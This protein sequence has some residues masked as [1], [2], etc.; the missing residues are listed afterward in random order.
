M[1]TCVPPPPRGVDPELDRVSDWFE[2][3]DDLEEAFGM[4]VRTAIDE[5]IDTP[6]TGRWNFNDCGKQELAYA[7]VK[8]E[9]VI[10]ARFDLASGL[11]R[12]DYCVDGVDVDCKWSKKWGGW[13]IPREAVGHVCLLVWGCDDDCEFAVGV[14]RIRGAIL[15]GGNQ[16]KKRKIQSP[17]G[18]GEIRWLVPC[19]NSLPPNFLLQLPDEDRKA[20]LGH[21]GGDARARELFLRCEGVIIRRHTIES[22]GQQI[23]E[24]RRF[25]GETRQEMRD[26]GF[27][28]LNGHWKAHQARALELGGVVLT[29]STE[30]VCLRTDG[31]TPHRLAAKP[32]QRRLATMPGTSVAS[33]SPGK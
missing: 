3:Q 23:D 31:S 25:R 26:L 5:V 7:G 24:A 30:W 33:K 1:L 20:I 18:R 10:R 12:M 13:E 11:N 32:Q 28:V 27:E 17:G 29:D 8:V 16:D 15:V 2:S 4:C 19:T 21:K 14:L 9:H 22:I 6:R